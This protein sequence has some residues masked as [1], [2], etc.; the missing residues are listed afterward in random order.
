M[1]QQRLS[2]GISYPVLKCGLQESSCHDCGYC[3]QENLLAYMFPSQTPN[4][5]LPSAE[6]NPALG[7]VLAHAIPRQF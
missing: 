4:P 5:N 2:V 7:A 1:E 6:N 3:L